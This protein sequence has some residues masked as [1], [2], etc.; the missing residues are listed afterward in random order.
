MDIVIPK[1]LSKWVIGYKNVG[2]SEY[3]F[4]IRDLP[5]QKTRIIVSKVRKTDKYLAE[6]N[7]KFKF[8][9]SGNR[10]MVAN[11]I[12]QDP[13]KAVILCLERIINKGEIFEFKP[14][15]SYTGTPF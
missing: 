15:N 2:L 5:L 11:G 14:N 1:N 9:G 4:Y 6:S 13:A 12:S 7:Y 8:K 3:E 10:F